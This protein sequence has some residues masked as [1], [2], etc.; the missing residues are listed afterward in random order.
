MSVKWTIRLGIVGAVLVVTPVAVALAQPHAAACA[1][2]EYRGLD[3]VATGILA[4]GECRLVND[5]SSSAFTRQRSS[6]SRTC[7]VRRVDRR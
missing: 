3:D 7:S 4:S 6:E 2:I 1:L 5:W